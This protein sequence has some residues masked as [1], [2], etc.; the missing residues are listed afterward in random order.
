VLL[1]ESSDLISLKTNP[2]ACLTFIDDNGILEI[3]QPIPICGLIYSKMDDSGTGTET[4]GLG[5]SRER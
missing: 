4:I 5:A 1:L 3:D 2:K